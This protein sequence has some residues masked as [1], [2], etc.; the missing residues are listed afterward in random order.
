MAAGGGNDT[1]LGGTAGDRLDG[2]HGDDMLDGGLGLDSLTGGSGADTF[3]FKTIEEISRDVVTDFDLGEGDR[4]DLSGLDA[5]TTVA[6]KQAF[7]SFAEGDVFSGAFADAGALFFEQSTHA[8]FGNVDAD[9]AADFSI[10][11]AGV[12]TLTAGAFRA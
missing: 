7:T 3:R 6:G 8:L 5:D 2:G 12:D 1:L 11:L 9:G 10:R 4:I